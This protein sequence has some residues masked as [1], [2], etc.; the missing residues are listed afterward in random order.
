VIVAQLKGGF[1]LDC[2][3][4]IMFCLVLLKELGNNRIK[5]NGQCS[6]SVRNYKLTESVITMNLSH[7]MSRS[8]PAFL[9]QTGLRIPRAKRV[10][11]AA[12]A[13]PACQARHHAPQQKRVSKLLC[14]KA[15]LAVL[16]VANSSP[17][18]EL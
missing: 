3:L 1:H 8:S 2:P 12:A 17:R 11:T 4:R 14:R 9:G 13:R 7:T 18:L 16:I 15:S 5:A 6:D 10:R